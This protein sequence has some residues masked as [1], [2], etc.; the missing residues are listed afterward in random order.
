MKTAKLVIGIIS[1]VLTLIIMLQSCAVGVGNAILNTGEVSGSAGLL[2][3]IFM[4][5]AGIVGVAARKSTAGGFV[6]GAF[7][8]VGGIIGVANYQSYYDLLIWSIVSFGFAAT[9]IIGSIFSKR[10]DKS[11]KGEKNQEENV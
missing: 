1:M 11:K 2:L 8:L 10:Q 7:Y 3:A 9:F 6:A 5:V 4:L